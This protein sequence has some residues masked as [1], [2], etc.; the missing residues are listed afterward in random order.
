MGTN[1]NKTS[2][3][4]ETALHGIAEG[5]GSTAVFGQ[6]AA[7]G[8]RGDGSTWNGVTGISTSTV[9]GAGVY[10][11]NDFGTG[12]KGLSK[13]WVGVYGETAAA[14]GAGASGVLGE[15]KDGG[16][17]VKG[18]ARGQGQAGVAGYQLA[19][20]G[21]GVYGEGAPAGFFKGDLVVTGDVVL[22]GADYAE[23]LTVAT[24]DVAPGMV[25]VLD[26]A[27]RI[28]PCEQ[29]YDTRVVGVV[30][31]A[32]GVRPALVLDRHAGGAPVALMGKVWALADASR[33]PI[34]PGDLLT[35]SATAGHAQRAGDLGRAVGSLIGRALTGL[36]GGH[37]LVRVLVG[38][39]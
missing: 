11:S 2:N 5:E 37:G 34:R 15:G 22:P 36:A 39:L 4:E 33:H 31:G 10:G 18:H 6:G 30:S 1:V 26:D 27:G 17:G 3:K 29:D 24:E 25:V 28:R 32:G 35:S 8:V 7:V 20:A 19:N 16:V 14:P 13:S 9:G 23:E 38:P 21:P 12:I